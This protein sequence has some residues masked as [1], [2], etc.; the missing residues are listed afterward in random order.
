M[1]G[2]PSGKGRGW[3]D[4]KWWDGVGGGLKQAGVTER[5]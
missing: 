4:S 5:F 2:L 1:V 3:G